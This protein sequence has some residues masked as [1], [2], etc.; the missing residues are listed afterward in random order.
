MSISETSTLRVLLVLAVTTVLAACE[1]R[2]QLELVN[3]NIYVAQKKEISVAVVIP[4]ST[5]SFSTAIDIPGGC[6]GDIIFVP[7][8]YG[9]TFQQ[10]I[11]DRF[12]RV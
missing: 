2:P 5:R 7:A 12:S 6:L 11:N 3:S 8:T 4:E 10:L 1:V 9:E